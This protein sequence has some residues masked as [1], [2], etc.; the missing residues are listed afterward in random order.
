MDEEA[1]CCSSSSLC[2]IFLGVD[3]TY[4]LLLW[5]S[6]FESTTN[7]GTYTK[8]MKMGAKSQRHK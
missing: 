4:N 3:A 1:T 6:P 2:C 5:I 8:I 7:H